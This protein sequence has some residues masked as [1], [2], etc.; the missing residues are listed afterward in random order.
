MSY[1]HKNTRTD[2]LKPG[3]SEREAEEKR[4]MVSSCNGCG[5]EVREVEAVVVAVVLVM[6]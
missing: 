3:S 5:G 2:A 1:T 6:V 4:L